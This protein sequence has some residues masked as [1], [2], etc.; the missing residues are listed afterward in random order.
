MIDLQKL[1]DMM[2]GD[3]D[4]VQKFLD[5]FKAQVK[6]QLPLMQQYLDTG[7]RPML[8]NAAHIM[9]TQT[10]YLGLDDLTSLSQ[11]VERMVDAGDD[12]D[13][14]R[15]HVVSL[16]EKLTLILQSDLA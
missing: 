11:M 7:N 13:A 4:L 5:A 6:T 9:K 12:L 15:P 2:D 14:I 8:S 3:T 1:L 10:A 16:V